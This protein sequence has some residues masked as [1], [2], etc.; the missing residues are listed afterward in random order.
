MHFM[1]QRFVNSL[2]I[3]WLQSLIAQNKHPNRYL[4][5]VARLEGDCSYHGMHIASILNANKNIRD[6][7]AASQVCI[8][9]HILTHQKYTKVQ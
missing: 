8:F 6:V 3:T 9:R 7:L 4:K 5:L 2:V 1:L